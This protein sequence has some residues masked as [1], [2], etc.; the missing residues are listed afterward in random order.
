M[1][2]YGIPYLI[3]TH[4]AGLAGTMTRLAVFH[5]KIIF[6]FTTMQCK[7]LLTFLIF[8]ATMACGQNLVPN[9]SFEEYLECPFS[10]AELQNQVVDWYSWQESPD[11]F[12]VCSN[13]LE[14]IAG[15][16]ENAW[17]YQ[18]P[19]TG[20]AYVGVATFAYPFEDIREYMACA[21][22]EPL[23]VGEQY[24]VMFYASLFDGGV[25]ADRHCATDK[26]GA[27]FFQNPDYSSEM[28]YNPY[29]PQN[30][31]D[32]EY[33]EMFTDTTD[34]ILIDGW[35]TADQAYNWLALGN[36]YDDQNTDTVQMGNP[37]ECYAF[38]YI[39]NVC[40]ATDPAECDY[41]KQEGDISS[42]NN[43]NNLST[44]IQVYPNPTTE[45]LRI[46]STTILTSVQLFNPTGQL[47]F[48]L[49][50]NNNETSIELTHWSKGLYI[51]KVEDENNHHQTFK[52]IKQ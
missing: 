37:G 44:N 36:F 25:L 41:L 12:H 2:E 23:E 15:V 42:V 29:I 51:L 22:N 50:E 40:V 31:S 19:I 11:F 27:K 32:I 17:G 28:P 7:V 45:V 3:D 5:Q 26:I 52:I 16:P 35:F 33:N 8:V 18:N 47:I 30:T 1:P 14:A 48:S 20:E 21:L 13:D 6:I 43:Q 39:E 9:P 49:G 38:Y 24:Y 34:W 46:K 10:T 4:R